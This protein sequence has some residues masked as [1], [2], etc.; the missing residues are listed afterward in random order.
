MTKN[1]HYVKRVAS[2]DK[3]WLAISDL[4]DQEELST[5]RLVEARAKLSIRLRDRR[6]EELKKWGYDPN[7]DPPERRT[8]AE[9]SAE[10]ASGLDRVVPL[11]SLAHRRF[12]VEVLEPL[13][14]VPKAKGKGKKKGKTKAPPAAQSN[15]GAEKPS[16][17]KG[18][19]ARAVKELLESK[20]G[21][22]QERRT[23]AEGVARML[24][25]TGVRPEHPLRRRLRTY[26][27][28]TST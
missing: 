20:E 16:G 27:D 9:A 6:A 10:A 12:R 21:D 2:E 4:I 26:L 5:I 24:A 22:E 25:V 15:G 18:R 1:R 13:L 17:P 8:E 14:A 7:V 23:L 28:K 3:G 11:I 19:L